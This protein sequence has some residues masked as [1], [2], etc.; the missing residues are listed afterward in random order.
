MCG[1]SVMPALC[2]PW[3]V[4]HQAPLSIG[5]SRQGYWSELPFPS[6]GD[7][8]DLGIEL[9]S[10]RRQA[11]SLLL[12]YRGIGASQVVPVVKKQPASAGDKE[13]RVRSLGWE[14]P[15]EEEM[16]TQESEATEVT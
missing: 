6:P 13:T 7:L 16:A 14:D 8:P 1:C 4:T 12:S 2:D 10:P 15:L 9:V 3:T 5:F 11:D